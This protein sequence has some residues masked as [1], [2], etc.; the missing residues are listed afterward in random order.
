MH[1]HD[2]HSEQGFPWPLWSITD[3]AQFSSAAVLRLMLLMIR[4]SMAAKCSWPAGQV[5]DVGTDTLE[6]SNSFLGGEGGE[7]RARLGELDN[8]AVVL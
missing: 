4:L 1:L 8:M 6:E 5:K 3:Q 7:R 2:R